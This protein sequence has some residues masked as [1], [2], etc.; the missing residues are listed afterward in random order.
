MIKAY[1]EKNFEAEVRFAKNDNV[2]ELQI[3]GMN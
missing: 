3:T 2:A 1:I